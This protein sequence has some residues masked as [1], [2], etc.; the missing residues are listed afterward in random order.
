MKNDPYICERDLTLLFLTSCGYNVYY[1]TMY[2]RHC[3]LVKVEYIYMYICGNGRA[4]CTPLVKNVYP[5]A[6]EA[7]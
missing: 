1:I 7:E 6:C 3:I 4:R 2:T 5:S